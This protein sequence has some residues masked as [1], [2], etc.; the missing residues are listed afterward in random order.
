MEKWGLYHVQ[1]IK[2]DGKGRAL[3]CGNERLDAIGGN[4]MCKLE[5]Q[6]DKGGNYDVDMKR[7][8]QQEAI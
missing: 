4:M 7:C 3:C 2:V 6:M 8:M 5:G 1:I